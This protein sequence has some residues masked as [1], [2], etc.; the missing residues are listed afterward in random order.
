MVDIKWDRILV[1]GEPLITM[2]M[3]LMISTVLGVVIALTYFTK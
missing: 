3:I 2:A 1:T